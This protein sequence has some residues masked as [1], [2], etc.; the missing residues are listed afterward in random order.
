MIRQ[1]NPH[2]PGLALRTVTAFAHDRARNPPAG[3]SEQ[4][5]HASHRYLLPVVGAAAGALGALAIFGRSEL[6]RPY[7]PWAL[8][9]LGAAA[10]A[11]S[12]AFHHWQLTHRA[13]IA[14]APPT[15]AD[16]DPFPS[17]FPGRLSALA[18]ARTTH[19]AMPHS[20][21]GRA[22][23]SAAAGDRVWKQWQAPPSAPLG[24]ALAGPVPETAYV[25]PRGGAE[26]AFPAR[27]RD[28]LVAV[29]PTL[30]PAA[31]AAARAALAP[32]PRFVPAPAVRASSQA[33]A[34]LAARR[35]IPFSDA[36]LDAMFPPDAAGAPSLPLASAELSPIP[37]SRPALSLEPDAIVPP[38]ARARSVAGAIGPGPPAP[39]AAPATPGAG[40]EAPTGRFRI[41][42][43]LIS[44]RDPLYVE[45]I[46]PI[47]PHLRSAPGSRGGGGSACRASSTRARGA[48]VSRACVGCLRRLSGFRGWVVCPGC[49]QAL[50]R[51]C[52]GA[53]FLASSEG[54]CSTCRP[55]HAR[56]A[57]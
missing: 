48:P 31:G 57:N 17:P 4:I 56:P 45:T 49:H 25:P 3:L 46:H 23:V 41:L 2:R 7:V 40:G 53:S 13:R 8:V 19:G 15:L 5:T 30:V 14:A 9:G 39:P 27:D 44:L 32:A 50:C 33:R 12:A 24:A 18:E 37:F 29:G 34:R 47:P 43:S 51:S 16:H 52:L 42:P 55:W 36:E 28:L 38:I 26:P 1:L 11:S 35:R 22:A 20:G 6:A 10:V 21:I 54:Y